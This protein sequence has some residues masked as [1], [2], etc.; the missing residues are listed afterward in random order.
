[1]YSQRGNALFLILIA[2]ALFAALSYAVTQ[3]GRGGSDIN[4]ENNAL[5]AA[6]LVQYG[7]MLDSELKRITILSNLQYF[8]L[9]YHDGFT[10]QMSPNTACVQSECKV[11]QSAGGPAL[12]PPYK[13]SYTQYV[14]SDWGQARLLIKVAY[15]YVKDVGTSEAEVILSVEGLKTAICSEINKQVTGTYA[16]PLEGFGGNLTGM[17]GNLTDWPT[18]NSVIIGTSATILSGQWEGCFKRRT[19]DEYGQYYKVLHAR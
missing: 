13:K 1:M 15:A 5:L 18:P 19:S 11:F 16:S 14:S 6:D 10:M 2:V 3:S 4:R 17:D 9:S 12:S 7:A 8:N